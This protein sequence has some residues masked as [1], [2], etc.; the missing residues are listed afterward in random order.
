MRNTSTIICLM[1]FTV[2]SPFL[3]AQVCP[4][5]P[6]SAAAQVAATIPASVPRELAVL[7][8]SLSFER[9]TSIT[10]FAYYAVS[11][12]AEQQWETAW[13][14]PV[15]ISKDHAF[16][17]AGDESTAERLLQ[18]RRS[19]SSNKSLTWILAITGLLAFGRAQQLAY[20]DNAGGPVLGV[21]SLGI[22]GGGV[23]TLIRWKGAKRAYRTEPAPAYTAELFRQY[24]ASL[25]QELGVT[26]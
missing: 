12:E 19:W 9:T 14:G 20:E 15:R 4:S 6:A 3:W 21:I 10:G 11:L 24:N 17:L 5:G 8:N 25:Q 22:L 16:C 2:R 13:R 7:Q 26:R 23:Y 18:L 1:L